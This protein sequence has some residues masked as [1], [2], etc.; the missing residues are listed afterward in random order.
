MADEQKQSEAYPMFLIGMIGFILGLIVAVI[1]I[2]VI[3]NKPGRG[4]ELP[5]MQKVA[6][7]A[8][9]NDVLLRYEDPDTGHT[10]Y[11]MRAGGGSVSVDVV[12]K[13]MK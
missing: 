8:I 11:V 4:Y 13:E 12:P 6:Q 9:E 5:K 1:G 10:V 3:T 7:G 2:G